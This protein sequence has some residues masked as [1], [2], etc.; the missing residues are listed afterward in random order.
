M[1]I[2][3]QPRSNP[4]GRVSFTSS[5][6]TVSEPDDQLTQYIGLI[7]TYVMLSIL[8]YNITDLFFLQFVHMFFSEAEVKIK[9]RRLLRLVHL[10][11]DF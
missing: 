4:C 11:W 1:S 3:I 2:I 7:R 5:V 6:Y 8:V 9:K 10:F